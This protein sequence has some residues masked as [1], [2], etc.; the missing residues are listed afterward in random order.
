VFFNLKLLVMHF[1]VL[2]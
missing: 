1:S 2:I